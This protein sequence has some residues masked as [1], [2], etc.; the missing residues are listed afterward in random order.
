MKEHKYIWDPTEYIRGG[1]REGTKPYFYS[2]LE[3]ILPNRAIV[4]RSQGLNYG[5]PESN[6]ISLDICYT[7]TIKFVTYLMTRYV[8]YRNYWYMVKR[9]IVFIFSTPFHA[10]KGET[11]NHVTYAPLTVNRKYNSQ[12]KQMTALEIWFSFTSTTIRGISNAD[13]RNFGQELFAIVK[14]IT[15]TSNCCLRTWAEGLKNG[16]SRG[17]KPLGKII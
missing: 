9:D 1:G 14:K 2:T 6:Y 3:T 16:A 15:A 17:R 12:I 4:F 11:S 8:G 7:Q 13:D 5:S 10:F